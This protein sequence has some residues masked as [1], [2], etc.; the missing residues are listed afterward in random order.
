MGSQRLIKESRVFR[1]SPLAVYDDADTL[2][3][4][5]VIRHPDHELHPWLVKPVGL[6]RRYA[7]RGAPGRELAEPVPIPRR[8][9]IA[10]FRK[11]R[12]SA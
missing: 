1:S 8:L 11:R 6:R 10:R 9:R 3:L 2:K 5:L 4:L 12:V 7:A